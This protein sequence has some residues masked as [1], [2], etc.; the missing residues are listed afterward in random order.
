MGFVLWRQFTLSVT[1]STEWLHTV[2]VGLGLIILFLSIMVLFN[3][4]FG[5]VPV[6]LFLALVLLF[7]GIEKV[8]IGFTPSGKSHL[9]SIGLGIIVIVVALIAMTFPTGTSIFIVMLF[10]I[11]LLIDGISR[12]VYTFRDNQ[13]KG[14]SKS[15]GIGVGMLSIIFALVIMTY[16]RT[17]LVVAGIFI[18]ISLFVTSVQ[19]ISDGMAWR[20]RR[21]YAALE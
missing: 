3:P 20:Q 8:I 14:K 1:E 4:I 21:K 10:G 9:I 2:Q 11:A 15:F 7:A 18:G 16:P 5:T 19:I 12:T 6:V 13:I 17:G